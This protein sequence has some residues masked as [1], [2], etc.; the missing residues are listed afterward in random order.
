MHF[1]GAQ[2]KIVFELMKKAEK[3]TISL[4]TEDENNGSEAHA[5]ASRL[6]RRLKAYAEENNIKYEI[7]RFDEDEEKKSSRS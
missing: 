2:L 3:L 7:K 1:S 4:G 5:L 6:L